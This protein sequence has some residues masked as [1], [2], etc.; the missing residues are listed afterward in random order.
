MLTCTEDGE[1]SC[2]DYLKM[3]KVHGGLLENVER[4]SVF[5]VAANINQCFLLVKFNRGMYYLLPAFFGIFLISC[6]SDKSES[7]VSMSLKANTTQKYDLND[8]PSD[9]R[10]IGFGVSPQV[11]IDCPRK[12]VVVV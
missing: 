5:Y 1:I 7:L 2:W 3:T 11:L 9:R 4:A 6:F 10:K 8:L 12:K